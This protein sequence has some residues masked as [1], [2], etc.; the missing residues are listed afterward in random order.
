[1]TGND[2]PLLLAAYRK[3]SG[4][5]MRGLANKSGVSVSTISR[6]ESRGFLPTLENFAAISRALNVSADC[7]LG[8]SP[9]ETL[10]RDGLNPELFGM[11][12]AIKKA[13]IE[14]NYG[15]AKP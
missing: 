11:L 1:M 8:Y 9:E 15:K 14:I 10:L 12:M 13:L 6:C 4:L 5:T 2:F 3:R 7:L